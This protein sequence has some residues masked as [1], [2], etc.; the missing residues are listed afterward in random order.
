MKIQ[1]KALSGLLGAALVIGLLATPALSQQAQPGPVTGPVVGPI[2]NTP[3]P[4]AAARRDALNKRLTFL[5]SGY[6]YFPDRATL[7]KE[8]AEAEVVAALLGFVRD[9]QAR[10]TLR[11]KAIDALGYY[12]V[13]ASVEALRPL[14][15]TP[16]AAG[17]P[18]EEERVQ[19]SMRHH[20]IM[21]LARAAGEQAVPWLKPLLSD[22]DLQ[23]QLTAVSALGKH[24]GA[25]GRAELTALKKTA[26]HPILLRELRKHVG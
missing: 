15:L 23:L 20:A 13:A 3:D 9:A 19:S 16:L 4:D 25:A 21:S 2:V 7:D 5:L 11:T 22:A 24:G 8:G 17:L 10:P 1:D 6:E 18:I 12:N 26:T 14:A